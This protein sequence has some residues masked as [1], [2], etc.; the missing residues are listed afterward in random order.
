MNN[1]NHSQRRKPRFLHSG[2]FFYCYL[3]IPLNELAIKSLKI[4]KLKLRK[5]I[6][7]ISM[8]SIQNAGK[9]D[10][11][12]SVSSQ[13]SAVKS[14]KYKVRSGRIV[15]DFSFGTATLQISMPDQVRYQVPISS[16]IFPISNF[17][18]QLPK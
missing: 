16:F 2:L 11:Q 13:Q 14:N 9:G 3:L 1:E 17:N 10:F 7:D 12:F 5:K 6:I 15:N 18:S 4:N 8:V